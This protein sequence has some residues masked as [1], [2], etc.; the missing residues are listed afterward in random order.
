MVIGGDPGGAGRA[1]GVRRG[2]ADWKH[3]S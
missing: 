3:L 1:A 2:A